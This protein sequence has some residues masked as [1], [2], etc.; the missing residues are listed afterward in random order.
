[1]NPKTIKILQFFRSYGI[2]WETEDTTVNINSFIIP[3]YYNMTLGHLN[4]QVEN[5]AN[6]EFCH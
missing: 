2:D 1:M 3:N 5:F 4:K 6:F